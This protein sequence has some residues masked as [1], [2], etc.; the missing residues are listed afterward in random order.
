MRNQ[1]IT[2]TMTLISCGIVF[3]FLIPGVSFLAGFQRDLAE[4]CIGGHV[5]RIRHVLD[6]RLEAEHNGLQ[7]TIQLN[8]ETLSYVCAAPLQDNAA[9]AVKQHLLLWMKHP[10]IIAIAASTAD[11][12]PVAA[13]WKTPE[14]AVGSQLPENINLNSDLSVTA[15]AFHNGKKTGN[16]HIYYTNAYLI[17]T[18]KI[19]ETI[20]AEAGAISGSMTR[21]LD[22]AIQFGFGGA[23]VLI[24]L[25]GFV[26][27]LTLK[28]L[29][30]N[31][32]SEVTD[33]ARKL[34]EY[35]LS[36]N[37]E[38]QGNHEVSGLMNAMKTVIE[39]FRQ[40]ISGIFETTVRLNMSIEG[41][42]DAS[43]NQVSV[44]EQQS[45]AISEISSTMEEFSA[46]SA[47][48]A[49]NSQAVVEIAGQTAA[50]TQEGVAAVEN[51]MEKMHQ[52]NEDNEHNVRQIEAL[53]HKTGEIAQVMGIINNI[54]DQT[55]LIAFNAAI[56]AA[57]A[58]DAGK[59][60]GVVAAEIRRL[61]DNVMESTDEIERKI[62]EIQEAANQMVVASESSTRGVR[63]GL[64]S[65]YHTASLLTETLLSA[66]STV[67]A[68]RQ[69][70]ISTRQQRTATGQV[71]EALHHISAGTEES[72]S[73]MRHMVSISKNLGELSEDLQKLMDKFKMSTE[74]F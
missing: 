53:R 5:K 15:G 66:Q 24:L 56:E 67:D 49:D 32:L 38:T 58:G 8:A 2:L 60:F 50:N 46:S 1:S 71:V 17:E 36:V 34:S 20:L 14:T 9:L 27:S 35:D 55:K 72:S 51:A 44:T 64:N 59:R 33:I 62:T 37:V 48:I 40:I 63:E 10:E 42:T 74:F 22:T 45:A 47:Q 28:K 70:S 23:V 29:L 12:T 25:Q 21:G 54:A 69:I 6:E 13:A 43:N 7:K 39:S 68:A 4:N 41:I 16:I 11:G 73:S 3:I 61:A 18:I 57:G 65:F 52:I 30:H 19:E 26:L 31:R